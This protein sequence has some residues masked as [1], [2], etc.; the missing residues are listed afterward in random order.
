M[1][2][3]TPEV[4]T[5]AHPQRTIYYFDGV[6]N[7]GEELVR[8]WRQFNKDFPLEPQ[9]HHLH[10]LLEQ[11]SYYREFLEALV[12]EIQFE[13]EERIH[14]K[15]IS[16][17]P[18][19]F[20]DMDEYDERLNHMSQLLNHTQE[21]Y[22]TPYLFDSEAQEVEWKKWD[23]ESVPFMHRWRNS[24]MAYRYTFSRIW[25]HGGMYVELY[26]P[27]GE[28]TLNEL[29]NK[30]V[31][32]VDNSSIVENWIPAL[33]NWPEPGYV[34]GIRSYDQFQRLYSFRFDD[35]SR[36]QID[37]GITYEGPI[38]EYEYD[39]NARN[40]DE[41]TD[42]P[43]PPDEEDH[44]Y[45]PEVDP[46][47]R[48]D[49]VVRP[50][51]K[52]RVL[53]LSVTAD[54]VF[55]R[56]ENSLRTTPKDNLC[57]LPLL[58]YITQQ[59]NRHRKATER[60]KVGVQV[61]L[62]CDTTGQFVKSGD[63]SYSIPK[64]RAKVTT[65]PNYENN[66]EPAYVRIG[67]GKLNDRQDRAIFRRPGEF[68][69]QALYGDVSAYEVSTYAGPDSTSGD[70]EDLEELDRLE[71]EAEGVDLDTFAMVNP[72]FGTALGEF[73]VN[74]VNA[75]LRGIN[76][77]IERQ[78]LQ[79]SS[80]SFNVDL[81]ETSEDSP[82]PSV[83]SLS[84]Q[85]ISP[86]SFVGH[87]N[88]ESLYIR[89]GARVE[90]P[91]TVS[92][93][94]NTKNVTPALF[95]FGG[96]DSD[97]QYDIMPH[98]LYD[99]STLSYFGG[100]KETP[101][102]DINEGWKVLREAINNGYKWLFGT[103]IPPDEIQERTY[104]SL[105][106]YLMSIPSEDEDKIQEKIE[107]FLTPSGETAEDPNPSDFS[108]GEINISTE[109]FQYI[110]TWMEEILIWITFFPV[111]DYDENGKVAEIPEDTYLYDA[112]LNL[113]GG[114]WRYSSWYLIVP[115]YLWRLWVEFS[116]FTNSN[117][118]EPSATY[119]I[120]NE[121][122]FR[123]ALRFQ[124]DE[125]IDPLTVSTDFSGSELVDMLTNFFS[126]LG[127]SSIYAY[128]R[129]DTDFT[130]YE[131]IEDSHKQFFT[132]LFFGGVGEVPRVV[133][134]NHIRIDREWEYT[135]ETQEGE[136]ITRTGIDLNVQDGV[137]RFTAALPSGME[138]F[139]EPT[140][141]PIDTGVNTVDE[142]LPQTPFT[143]TMDIRYTTNMVADSP[144][145][146]DLSTRV[147]GIT[148]AGIFNTEGDLI[149]YAT[150]P[151]VIYDTRNNHF[152]LNWYISSLAFAAP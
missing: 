93:T 137:L 144:V 102:E 142:R 126:T 32:L 46:L 9:Y 112:E 6:G 104:T 11:S 33:G 69:R 94:L 134:H 145:S 26:Y 71:Q 43:T 130:F 38:D 96:K 109:G 64:I 37:T 45:Y 21:Y 85:H 27:E 14:K 1:P 19:Y 56:Q 146:Q 125:D 101:P 120:F 78:E 50:L 29:S 140:L 88:L 111:G 74:D 24:Y 108:S 18:S 55:N 20:I 82:E 98:L 150:F 23:I 95:L 65:L 22:L 34:T 2:D 57:D 128:T 49:T 10:H 87:L 59:G 30:A 86:G 119:Y 143:R 52:D 100:S 90:D 116:E 13:I 25:M 12:E 79:G 47:Y 138:K 15:N 54:R 3:N 136:E 132:P 103:I 51:V 115:Q 75:Q 127:E 44:K 118:R 121:L 147:V 61:N 151:P 28:G 36:P 60:I 72:L 99:F 76:T 117:E 31:R 42:P 107:A 92:L 97:G 105:Q 8:T 63:S 16:F 81:D 67:N 53:V 124:R 148:E 48:F 73:E 113:R 110:K 91:D 70:P 58:Q 40:E 84:H 89:I 131:R 122:S 80:G 152:A 129:E 68:Q 139:Y 135:W 5:P 66:N 83:I 149:A 41:V 39:V 7:R 77:M 62:A 114:N 17:D 106:E 123:E 4:T 133:K 35:R 141:D